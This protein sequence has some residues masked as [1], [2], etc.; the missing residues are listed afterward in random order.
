MLRAHEGA[1]P[2]KQ[3]G[4]AC[5]TPSRRHRRPAHG[6][7]PIASTAREPDGR[8]DRHYLHG[9]RRY[10]TR[11]VRHGRAAVGGPATRCCC[12]TCS[13]LRLYRPLDSKGDIRAIRGPL[14]AASNDPQFKRAFAVLTPGRQ[15]GYL[16]RFAN[17]KQSGTR[18]ARIEKARP[19]ILEGRGFLERR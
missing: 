19:A 2:L 6:G 15:R 18:I 7:V 4:P 8:G 9:R 13:S 14:I 5:S 17:A 1:W 3:Q 10:P 11:R 12:P 16:F